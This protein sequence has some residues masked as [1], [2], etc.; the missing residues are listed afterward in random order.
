MLT[1]LLGLL[2][3]DAAGKLGCLDRHRMHRHIA[4]E[5]IDKSLSALPPLLQLG[6]LD[7]VRQLHDGHHRKTDLGFSVASFELLQ[8]LPHGVALA[9]SGNDHAGIED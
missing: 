8:D 4:D 7:T 3:F 9:L 2:A 1:S 5:F 6:A